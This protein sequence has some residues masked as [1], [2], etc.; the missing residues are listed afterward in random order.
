MDILLIHYSILV[1]GIKLPFTIG[2][3][4]DTPNSNAAIQLLKKSGFISLNRSNDLSKEQ[5][6]LNQAI[7]REVILK[8]PLTAM[9][10]NGKR[11]QGGKIGKPYEADSCLVWLHV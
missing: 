4:E 10:L 8:N 3:Q 6:Y 1:A 7:I 2:S 5:N 11:L 9:F